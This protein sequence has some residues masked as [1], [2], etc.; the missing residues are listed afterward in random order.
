VNAKPSRSGLLVVGLIIVAGVIFMGGLY[1]TAWKSVPAEYRAATPGFPDRSLMVVSWDLQWTLDT[2]PAIAALRKHEPDLV[3]LQQV[4][5]AQAQEIAR[6]LDMKHEGELQM[7]YSQSNEG[8]TQEPGNAILARFPLYQGREMPRP[9]ARGFGVF[10]EPVVGGK[11]FLVGCVD[12]AAD[13]NQK[14]LEAQAMERAW[15]QGGSVPLIA[16]GA[17]RL[18]GVISG[19]HGVESGED[20]ILVSPGLAIDAW[21]DELAS[22]LKQ[23]LIWAKVSSA[24]SATQ[25][26]SSRP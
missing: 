23:K 13:T 16:A 5:R 17:F 4:T 8:T 26:A 11:R 15:R 14:T 1:L 9:T 21:G 6:A 12:L 20:H 3:L 22:P 18:Q 7:M 25:G 19:L 2:Q 24:I 10:D